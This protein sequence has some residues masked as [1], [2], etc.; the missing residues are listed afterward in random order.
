MV[1]DGGRGA[2]GHRCEAEH[3][4]RRGCREQEQTFHKTSE[5]D[6]GQI[7]MGTARGVHDRGD[8]NPLPEYA[9]NGRAKSPA[10]PAWR[11]PSPPSGIGRTMPRA[12]TSFASRP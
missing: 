6:V 10:Q 9:Q 8:R 4:A 2:C 7:L 1:E 5:V 3:G 11:T 12:M